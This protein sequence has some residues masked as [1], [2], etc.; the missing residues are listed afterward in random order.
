MNTLSHLTPY[1]L[2]GVLSPDGR[3]KSFDA[4][5]NGY[6]R[7]EAIG[8]V[9]LQK[10]K[11]AKRIYATV[12]HAKTNCDGF[13][14][15][16]IT[17]PSSVMQS[18]LFK[19]CYEECGLPPSCLDYL[20]A[21]GTGTVVGDPEELNAID[22]IFCAG[23]T[24]PLR[25]GSIKSNL[26]HAEPAS[27]ICSI[28]KVKFKPLNLNYNYSSGNFHKFCITEKFSRSNYFLLFF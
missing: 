12:V 13:K 1:R 8:M 16:G 15:Q 23:R 9:Y 25:I 4:D 19:E 20:E 18:R 24:T 28:A 5:A 22:K 11:D 21:H 6:T 3:C 17:F 27:G 10:S 2:S 26:G 7:A 14:E